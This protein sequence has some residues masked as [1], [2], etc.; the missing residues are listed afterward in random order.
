MRAPSLAN[1]WGLILA[2]LGIIIAG[3][4]I[5]SIY[6]KKTFIIIGIISLIFF[7]F[8][9]FL[10]LALVI[11]DYRDLYPTFTRETLGIKY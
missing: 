6:L 8:L 10:F 1:M 4:Q 3:L 9:F 5:E 11:R 2:A 7:T